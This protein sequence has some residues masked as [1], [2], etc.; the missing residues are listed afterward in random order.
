MSRDST[1]L[2]KRPFG[3]VEQGDS[4]EKMLC[5]FVKEGAGPSYARVCGATFPKVSADV[6][7]TV[8][9]FLEVAMS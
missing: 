1:F 9:I 4:V 5:L 2:A 6:S 7:A 3:E 8:G